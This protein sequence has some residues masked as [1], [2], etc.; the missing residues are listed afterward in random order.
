MTTSNDNTLPVSPRKK[1]TLKR[2]LMG[3][4]LGF[5][6][7]LGVVVL[8]V[9]TLFFLA[10]HDSKLPPSLRLEV[11]LLTHDNCCVLTHKIN[12]AIRDKD[13]AAAR[14]YIDKLAKWEAKQRNRENK[15][16]VYHTA[17]SFQ[18]LLYEDQGDYE[19]AL[20]IQLKW[21]GRIR[22][23]QPHGMGDGIDEEDFYA[24]PRLLYKLDRKEEAFVEY[25]K[26][27]RELQGAA[28]ILASLTPSPEKSL[29]GIVRKQIQERLMQNAP[30][31]NN[32]NSS[33]EF[34]DF[35]QFA[36]EEYARLGKPEEYA[37][38][39]AIFHAVNDQRQARQEKARD[40]QG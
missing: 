22:I 38:V 34:S 13:Y 17:E 18:S 37:D 14:K 32:D 35:L 8:G 10:S 7:T 30:I 28:R 1:W 39:M 31:W 24:L 36:D 33:P 19:K 6:C 23:R 9:I 26:A 27:T 25:C 11:D 21:Q 4:L 15:P 12:E 3:L 2:M 20:D 40:N 16:Y 29:E 5:F